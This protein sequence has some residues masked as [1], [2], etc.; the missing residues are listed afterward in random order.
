MPTDN[1]NTKRRV[2]DGLRVIIEKL[3]DPE[4]QLVDWSENVELGTTQIP[5]QSGDTFL[6][7]GYDGNQEFALSITLYDP[8]MNA[9]NPIN[10]DLTGD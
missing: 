1:K 10:A 7:T 3:E 6:R 9:L 2:A 8:R 4:I 5:Y